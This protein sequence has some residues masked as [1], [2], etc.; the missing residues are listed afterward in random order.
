MFNNGEHVRIP[1]DG[2]SSARTSPLQAFMNID[3]KKRGAA[4]MALAFIL[5][6]TFLILGAAGVC[7]GFMLVGLIL[8]MIPNFMGM[9]DVRVMSVFGVVFM[10]MALALGTFAFSVPMIH[11]NSTPSVGGSEYITGLEAVYDGTGN[12]IEFTVTTS[13]LSETQEATVM[14]NRVVG[15]SYSLITVQDREYSTLTLTKV[16]EGASG[17]TWKGS[18]TDVAY[19][20][21]YIYLANVVEPAPVEA[22]G[23]VVVESSSTPKIYFTGAIS[24]SGIQGLCLS[25]NAYMI[26]M[27][28]V[29]FYVVLFGSFVMRRSF[30]NT[31]VKMEAEG[32]LYPKGYGRC[33]ECGTVVLPGEVCC[34]KCGAYVEVPEEMRPKKAEFF[35]CSECGAEVPADAKVCPRCGSEFEDDA[36][37][38]EDQEGP[39]ECPRCEDGDEG[40]KD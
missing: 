3:P 17:E 26:A 31:R 35:E 6:L 25:G 24:D 11:D 7:C 10:L 21:L 30:E 1:M 32:R 18:I 27:I 5:G 13:D 19:G 38:E 33:K 15:A 20:T 8:Y 28:M 37:G 34:R 12:S 36:E 39:V 4:G 2:T 22:S 40:K 14:Y 29:V 16:S 9:K 23:T